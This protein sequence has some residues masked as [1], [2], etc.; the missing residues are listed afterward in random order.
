MSPLYGNEPS[1]LERPQWQSADAATSIM[2]TPLHS[3][4]AMP[5]LGAASASATV[6]A[7]LHLAA[8]ALAVSAA[9]LASSVAALAALAAAA[10]ALSALAARAAGATLR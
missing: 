3:A 5:P 6:A 1:V 2:E 7:A 4:R 8:A 10:A 9:A